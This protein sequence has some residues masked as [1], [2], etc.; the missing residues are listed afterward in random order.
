MNFTLTLLYHPQERDGLLGV[1][2]MKGLV[3]DLVG[4]LSKEKQHGDVDM[5]FPK[6]DALLPPLQI[7]SF[8]GGSCLVRTSLPSDLRLK[9]MSLQDQE[10]TCLLGSR[11]RMRSASFKRP[12]FFVCQEA[13]MQERDFRKKRRGA[14][15]PNN[16]L[17]RSQ[18]SRGAKEGQQ[19]EE[20]KALT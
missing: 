12:L 19:V 10:A 1:V 14:E 20:E 7:A 4:M 13:A 18:R 17:K 5:I 6:E 11:G 3:V 2:F 8:S 9:S 15:K 16:N